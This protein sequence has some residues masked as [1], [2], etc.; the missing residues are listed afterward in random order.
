MNPE[1]AVQ[2][3]N[4]GTLLTLCLLGKG[5]YFCPKNLAEEMMTPAEKKK[6]LFLA[7]PEGRYTICFGYTETKHPWSVIGEF[8]RMAE[9]EKK[10]KIH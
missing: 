4:M 6:L 9:E 10:G 7:L 2:S 5:A 3:E 1:I 8:I